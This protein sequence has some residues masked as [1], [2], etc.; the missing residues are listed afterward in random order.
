MNNCNHNCNQG[1]TCD[2]VANEEYASSTEGPKIQGGPEMPRAWVALDT[3]G[4][5]V[6][7]SQRNMQRGPLTSQEIAGMQN[8][9]PQT[10]WD[11]AYMKRPQITMED[12]SNH[13]WDWLDD[14]GDLYKAFIA[15]FFCAVAGVIVGYLVGPK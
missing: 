10:L 11:K 3:E 13:P 12:D 15:V 4:N 6:A 2:C 8:A 9:T 1:R 14:L 5:I 7:M